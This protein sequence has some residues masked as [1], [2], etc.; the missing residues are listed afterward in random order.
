[1]RRRSTGSVDE[2]STARDGPTN[3]P[4]DQTPTSLRPAPV[5][6]PRRRSHDDR[7]ARGR[8]LG[9]T[10]SLPPAVALRLV[11]SDRH[12]HRGAVGFPPPAPEGYPTNIHQMKITCPHCGEEFQFAV[13]NRFVSL[14]GFDYSTLDWS[15]RTPQLCKETGKSQTAILA[16]R[17]KLAPETMFGRS[18]WNS[19]DWS[20]TNAQ[21]ARELKTSTK[22]VS[23]NRRRVMANPPTPRPP[24]PLRSD[25]DGPGTSA[26]TDHEQQA[27]R[28]DGSLPP[29]QPCPAPGESPSDEPA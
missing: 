25:S 23:H 3:Q 15:K 8:S 19:V 20:K 11:R 10:P 13:S 17:R 6:R 2:N 4:H 21:I 9:Q 5:H 28:N 18:R 16:W 27:S 1:M 29:E 24:A 7:D 26:S 12:P 14:D 22:A